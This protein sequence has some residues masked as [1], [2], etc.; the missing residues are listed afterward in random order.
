MLH[1]PNPITSTSESD[2]VRYSRQIATIGKLSQPKGCS[3]TSKPKTSAVDQEIRDTLRREQEFDLQIQ[4]ELSK[5][6][7]PLDQHAKHTPKLCMRR[8]S[9]RVNTLAVSPREHR[10][11]HRRMQTLPASAYND[12][13]CTM[14][15]LYPRHH[16]TVSW[17]DES[18]IKSLPPLIKSTPIH[19]D[20]TMKFPKKSRAVVIEMGEKSRIANMVDSVIEKCSNQKLSYSRSIDF[21]IK[22]C[23]QESSDFF[24]FVE[25]IVDSI[26][27]G[28][29]N[30]TLDNAMLSHRDDQKLHKNLTQQSNEIRDELKFST[31]KFMKHPTTKKPARRSSF[32]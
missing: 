7:F 6:N 17:K 9:K 14:N 24:C 8:R 15:N 26:K 19:L 23:A 5:L 25:R 22:S 2:Y 28:S 12:R 10:V 27:F 31:L 30:E 16:P 13:P 32:N 21:G 29:A 4:K 3:R 11:N 18:P 1:E 20:P